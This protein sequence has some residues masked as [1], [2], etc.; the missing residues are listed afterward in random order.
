M[1]ILFLA[2]NNT[3]LPVPIWTVHDVCRSYVRGH[4]KKVIFTPFCT[5][6]VHCPHS[7]DCDEEGKNLS[8]KNIVK[9]YWAKMDL[10]DFYNV[11]FLD[12]T[13][14]RNNHINLYI[15]ESFFSG[16]K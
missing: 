16:L 11:P 3:V 13:N 1:I 8:R 9:K 5:Y 4:A 15:I 7:W 2:K 14:K 10:N 6:F 12:I